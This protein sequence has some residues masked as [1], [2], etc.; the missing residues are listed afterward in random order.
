[1]AGLEPRHPSQIYQAGLEGL[2]LFAILLLAVRS[3]AL[4]RPGIVGGLFVA[5][6]GVARVIGELFRQPDA[7]IGF[8]AGGLTMGMILSIPM[9]LVGGAVMIYALRRPKAA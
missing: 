2:A 5:G 9:I 6:Y 3:G 4:H 7:Q 8:L 1:M